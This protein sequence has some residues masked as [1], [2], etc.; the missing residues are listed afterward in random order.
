M[1]TVLV[2]FGIFC[3]ATVITESIIAGLLWQ[4]GML[5]PE[6][7]HEIQ[8]ILTGAEDDILGEESDPKDNISKHTTDQI[9]ETRVMRVLNMEQRMAELNAM[10]DALDSSWE[11]MLAEKKSLEDEQDKFKQ[12]KERDRLNSI[13]EA[14]KKAQALLGKMTPEESV[15]YLMKLTTDENITILKGMQE[16]QVVAILSQFINGGGQDADQMR[17]RGHEIFNALSVVKP[18][19]G[20]NRISQSDGNLSEKK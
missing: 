13:S 4:Q 17:A 1:K 7:V 2:L 9:V 6:A 3:T 8:D 20:L 10:K 18:I 12:A 19:T 5:T 15:T 14:T 16:K 11:E